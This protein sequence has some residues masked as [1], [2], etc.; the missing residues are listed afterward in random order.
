MCKAEPWK[1][2]ESTYPDIRSLQLPLLKRRLAV[3]D[4][5]MDYTKEEYLEFC[6]RYEQH[7]IEDSVQVR[8]F[9]G[10]ILETTNG[11]LIV[12]FLD[13]GNWDR[14]RSFSF[15]QESRHLELVWHNFD[16]EESKNSDNWIRKAIWPADEYRLSIILDRIVPVRLGDVT[17]FALKGVAVPD[18]DLR[19]NNGATKS[20]SVLQDY[21]FFRKRLMIK[22]DEGISKVI[23]CHCTPILSTLILPKK[24]G[25]TSFK[26]AHILYLANLKDLQFRIGRVQEFLAGIA[27]DDRDSL[28]GEAA[29]SRIVLEAALKLECCL[30]EVQPQKSYSHLQ[31]GQLRK[32]LRDS[33][34]DQM[35]EYL[36]QCIVLL[37]QLSHDSGKSVSKEKATAACA[38]VATYLMYLGTSIQM[39]FRTYS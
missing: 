37:N 36:K 35:S 9:F 32:A 33:I 20:D 4:A 10:E 31:L 34:D 23:D 1:W 21:G 19:T 7:E 6:R 16:E 2:A 38:L 24:F 22:C 13:S 3:G 26:S 25:I 11:Q 5:R 18:N 14:I 28:C 15:H 39:E 30:R 12:D 29:K 17:I 27:E 8:D